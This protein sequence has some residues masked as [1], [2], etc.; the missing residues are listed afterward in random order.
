MLFMSFIMQN[1]SRGFKK[2]KR[3][4][5]RAFASSSPVTIKF[6]ALRIENYFLIW[7]VAEQAPVF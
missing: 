7:Q 5:Y 4:V 6:I 3:T 2:K 1:D